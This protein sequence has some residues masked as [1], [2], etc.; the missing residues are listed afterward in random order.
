LF[1]VSTKGNLSNVDQIGLY[2]IKMLSPTDMT[3]PKQLSM[4][5]V[6]YSLTT[7]GLSRYTRPV[8]AETMRTDPPDL[9]NQLELFE[10]T[11]TAIQT[12]SNILSSAIVEFAPLVYQPLRNSSTTASQAP[13]YY[14]PVNSVRLADLPDFL[15]ILIAYV[16]KNDWANSTSKTNYMTRRITLPAA[17]ASRLP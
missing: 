10:N 6:A 9:N 16:D 17:Q 8:Q 14:L 15:D 7:N 11:V 13:V 5:F 2:F 12:P 1:R 3:D 4:E